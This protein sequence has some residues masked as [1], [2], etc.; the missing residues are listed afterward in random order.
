MR[1]WRASATAGPGG[2]WREA[3]QAESGAGCVG[4]GDGVTGVEAVGTSEQLIA[5]PKVAARCETWAS[6]S[7]RTCRQKEKLSSRQDGDAERGRGRSRKEIDPV[8]WFRIIAVDT[9]IDQISLTGIVLGDQP[10]NSVFLGAAP[11]PPPALPCVCPAAPRPPDL[12]CWRRVCGTTEL[13]QERAIADTDQDLRDLADV[14][15]IC[16]RLMRFQS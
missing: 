2:G 11:V 10:R 9:P 1:S 4:R 5:Q 13:L 12:A 15:G 16:G 3:A 14:D 6:P 8:K 7:R